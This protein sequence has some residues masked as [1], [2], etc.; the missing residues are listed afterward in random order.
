MNTANTPSSPPDLRKDMKGL[1]LDLDGCLYALNP[2]FIE[3]LLQAW[4]D[5][6]TSLLSIAPDHPKYTEMSPIIRDMAMVS[7]RETG[8][9]YHGFIEAFGLNEA[10]LHHTHH[11]IMCEVDGNLSFEENLAHIMH[12]V[13]SDNTLKAAILTHSNKRWATY[14]LSLLDVMHLFP[15]NRIIGFECADFQR[16]SHSEQPFRVALDRLELPA[17]KV[18]MA[19]DTVPNL[20]IPKQLGMK[21]VWVKRSYTT[22]PESFAKK[23]TT[24]VNYSHIDY[25]FPTATDFFQNLI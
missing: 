25:I 15:A 3:V 4:V 8:K 21:T 13:L 6:V 16:K 1:I 24:V 7:Y 5:T 17:S 20:I 10:D 19:E 12:T 22:V 18:I 14:I 23:D 11:N 9:A 2:V